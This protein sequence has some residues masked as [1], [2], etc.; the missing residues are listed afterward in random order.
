MRASLEFF[1]GLLER[2]N[3]GVAWG[4]FTGLHGEALRLLQ[5]MGFVASEPGMNPVPSCPYCL[6]GSPYRLEDRYLCNG[7]YSS[8]ELHHLQLWPVRLDSFLVWL[9]TQLGLQGQ[10]RS[11]DGQLWELG[12]CTVNTVH[13]EVFFRRQAALTEAEKGRLAVF[14]STLLLYGVSRSPESDEASQVLSIL[15]VL[16]LGTALTVADLTGLLHSGANVRFDPATGVLRLGGTPV[17]DVPFGSKEC[18]FLACLAEKLDTF[19][20]YSDIKTFVQRNTGSEQD[21]DDATFCQKLKNR[22]KSRWIPGI[23]RLIVTT[24]KANGYRLRAVADL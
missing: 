20:P 9:A 24:N 11:I 10:L 15:D 3:A 16:D 21:A 22:I 12:S 2:D 6:D 18:F 5:R 14:R 1:V 7:C 8:V 23:D 13:Y 4:D 19:V 17:G